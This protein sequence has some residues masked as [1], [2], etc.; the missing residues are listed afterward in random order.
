MSCLVIQ[1]HIKIKQHCYIFKSEICLVSLLQ[2]TS[3]VLYLDYTRCQRHCIS[4][5]VPLTYDRS[6]LVWEMWHKVL[7]W[8]THTTHHKCCCDHL[9]HISYIQLCTLYVS[10]PPEYANGTNMQIIRD[11]CKI[12][13][14]NR[15]IL[16]VIPPAHSMFLFASKHPSLVDKCTLRLAH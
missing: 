1:L 7:L 12:T 6:S 3:G 13:I 10:T 8:S 5:A 15:P 9:F 2:V 14:Q 16:N 11:W 4:D